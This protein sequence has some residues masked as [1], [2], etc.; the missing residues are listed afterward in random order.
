MSTRADLPVKDLS[1]DL[2]NFRTVP[3]PDQISAVKA[4]I[5]INPD[6][7]WA[8]MESILSDGYLPTENIIVLKETKTRLVVREGNRRVAI[9]KI[10]HG[11]LD[12]SN[13]SI[14]TDLTDRIAKVTDEWKKD[15][16]K[17]PCAVYEKKDAA[18]V[19]KIVALTHGKAEKAGRDEWESVAT[20]RHNRATGGSEP[21]LDLLEKYLSNGQNLTTQQK[22][23]WAGDYHLTVLTEAVSRII[24]RLKIATPKDL[25]DKYPKLPKRNE[26]EDIMREIG[27]E[28]ITFPLLRDTTQDVLAQH[29]I[30]PLTTPSGSSSGSGA[31]SGT[32]STSGG[33]SGGGSAGSQTG[34]RR[35]AKA[36][37]INDPRTVKATLKK[38]NPQGANRQKVATLK[39]ELLALNMVKNPLAFCFL[40]RSMFEISAKAYCDD[41]RIALKLTKTKKGKTST[42]DKTLFELLKEIVKHL[43]NNNKDKAKL[44]LLHGAIVQLGKTDGFLSVTSMNHLVHNPSFSITAADISTLFGNIY[45]LLEFMN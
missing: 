24:P 32:G 6:W 12:S 13:F 27:V 22:D 44:K 39:E 11:Y 45:P 34:G 30:P 31:G 42:Y 23:R 5:S 4:M 8:L 40:L 9:L 33:S 38:F 37:P 28:G 19:D 3:Q 43:T 26:L 2:F 36:H 25:V 35:G 7:F 14:P 17:V 15:N 1:L 29:G 20:A 41:N 18:M 21:S 10:I 16:E